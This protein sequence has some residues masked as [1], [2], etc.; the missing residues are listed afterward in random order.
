MRS[1]LGLRSKIADEAPGQGTQALGVGA[2]QDVVALPSRRD[3]PGRRQLLQVLRH[4]RLGAAD[5]PRDRV[6]S[7]TSFNAC[8]RVAWPSASTTCTRSGEGILGLAASIT[9]GAG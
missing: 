7:V 2:V 6:R 8:S 9:N 5:E 4:S 1:P 3:E